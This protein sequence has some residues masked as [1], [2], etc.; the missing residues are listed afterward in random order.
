MARTFTDD[1]GV[2]WTV[3][4]VRPQ[5]RERRAPADRRSGSDRRD[6]TTPER[7]S[8][9]APGPADGAERRGGPGDRRVPL[10]RRLSAKRRV[11]LPT[12]LEQGWLCFEGGGTR[13]RLA[14]I[15]ADWEQCADGALL[16]YCG[17]ARAASSSRSA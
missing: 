4:A 2:S 5:G 6:R 8:A 3:W 16:A 12:A 7:G 17:A 10:E 1:E 15:P 13:R 9:A 14:P 11:V